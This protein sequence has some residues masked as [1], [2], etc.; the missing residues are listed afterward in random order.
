MTL[1][2]SKDIHRQ[3]LVTFKGKSKKGYNWMLAM[4]GDSR[5][6]RMS[7]ERGQEILDCLV[8]KAYAAT[9]PVHRRTHDLFI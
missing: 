1:A 2:L 3:L 7:E 5:L 6:E 9:C 8:A 4:F